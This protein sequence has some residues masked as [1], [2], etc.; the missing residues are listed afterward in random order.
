MKKVLQTFGDAKTFVEFAR[1]VK[2]NHDNKYT[3][4]DGIELFEEEP[5][6]VDFNDFVVMQAIEAIPKYKN[7]VAQK[8][9]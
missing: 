3:L 6:N 9:V 2:E 7:E 8:V 5:E 1:Y 4:S